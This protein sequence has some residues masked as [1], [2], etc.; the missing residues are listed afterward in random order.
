MSFKIVNVEGHKP[1]VKSQ[2]ATHRETQ[3]RVSAF[4]INT[5]II[6][7]LRKV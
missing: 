3:E 4:A 2:A 1:K 7:Y 6:D 5:G